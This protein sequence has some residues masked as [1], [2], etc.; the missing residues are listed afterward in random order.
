M[1]LP[2]LMFS[3]CR[4][5]PLR[6]GLLVDQLLFDFD[7][8]MQADED[9]VLGQHLYRVHQLADRAFIPFGESGGGGLQDAARV[10]NALRRSGAVLL[11]FQKAALFGSQGGGIVGD[12]FELVRVLQI[13]AAFF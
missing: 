8:A 9:A 1:F 12:T 5:S 4:Y 2:E 3:V 6:R 10:L 7:A 13:A 11:S